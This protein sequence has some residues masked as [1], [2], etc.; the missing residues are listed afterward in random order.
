[1]Q[2]VHYQSD[3][4][5][6]EM[7]VGWQIST[8][9]IGSLVCPK[10]VLRII[11]TTRKAG[12]HNS[13]NCCSLLILSSEIQNLCVLIDQYRADFP[14]RQFLSTAVLYRLSKGKTSLAG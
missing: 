7:P 4:K 10:M 9:L 11:R 1:M 13:K 3:A 14:I 12:E 5:T 6:V 8:L 2:I